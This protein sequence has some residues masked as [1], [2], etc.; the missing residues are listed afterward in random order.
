MKMA[1]DFNTTV[2]SS[3]SDGHDHDHNNIKNND[4]EDEKGKIGSYYVPR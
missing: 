4:N 3:L 2:I 1:R